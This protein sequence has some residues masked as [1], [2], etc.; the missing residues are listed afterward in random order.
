M[1]AP[2]C[3][4]LV[5]NDQAYNRRLSSYF[6]EVIISTENPLSQFGESRA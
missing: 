1:D 6:T 3:S 4:S 5:G 2:M